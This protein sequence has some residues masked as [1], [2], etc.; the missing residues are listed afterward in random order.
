M[1]CT[2]HNKTFRPSRL[3]IFG[4]ITY[5]EQ[6]KEFI[7][8]DIKIYIYNFMSSRSN[9]DHISFNVSVTLDDVC[10]YI[11]THTVFVKLLDWNYYLFV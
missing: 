1:Y 9:W 2:V 8:R 10:I 3:A 6:I 4:P 7:L 5:Q 11:H